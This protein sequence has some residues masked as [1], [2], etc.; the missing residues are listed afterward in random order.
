MT[1]PVNKVLLFSSGV[2]GIVL[3]IEPKALLILTCLFPQA[4]WFSYKVLLSVWSLGEVPVICILPWMWTFAVSICVLFPV[5]Q[6]KAV[7]MFQDSCS[8]LTD[9]F[10]NHFAC[11]FIFFITTGSGQGATLLAGRH[12]LGIFTPLVDWK[13]TFSTVCYVISLLTW[14]LLCTRI[15]E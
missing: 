14:R 1:T 11:F 3:S 10:A 9:G 15:G 12:R 4:Y 5:A 8:V 6:Q 2:Q 7:G 13:R